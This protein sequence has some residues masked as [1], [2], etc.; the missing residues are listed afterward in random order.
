MFSR[1]SPYA[2]AFI[3]CGIAL[4]LSGC[5]GNPFKKEPAKPCPSVAMAAD[6]ANL[7]QFKPGPGRDITDVDVEAEIIS[8]VGSC[9]YKK[10]TVELTLQLVIA[11]TRG[12]ANTSRKVEFAYFIAVP[13][14]FPAPAAKEV[15]PVSIEFPEGMNQVRYRDGEVTMTIP[16]Q[17]GELADKYEVYVGMQLT[18]AQLEYNRQIRR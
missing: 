10:D 11:A 13:A 16:L 5:S 9:G 15:L 7:T 8:F 4:S 17:P 2:L 18:P 14:F 6:T 1:V 12:P 3:A